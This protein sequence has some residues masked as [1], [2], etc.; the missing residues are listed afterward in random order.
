MGE[1]TLR[2]LGA[3]EFL[4]QDADPSGTTRVDA[5]NGFNELSRLAI[6]WTVRHRWPAE[7][8]F[9][10]NCYRHWAQLLL[11][12]LGEQPVTILSK[13]GVTQGDSLSMVLC[14][15]TLV[16][17]T[18]ELRAADP[19]LL[20]PFYADDSAFAGSSRCSAP[21]VKLLMKRGPDR[22]YF[23]EPAKSLFILDTLGQ[24]AAEKTEFAV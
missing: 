14:G 19:G 1:G 10:F 18:E 5:C 11:C 17:L 12:Q 2:A 16:P 23:P 7:V 3:L 13:E 20:L 9:T 8:K 24:E 21:L 15:I 22:G 6:M 4:T